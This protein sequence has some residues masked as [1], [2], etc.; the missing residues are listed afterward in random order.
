[1]YKETTEQLIDK[2]IKCFDDLLY[3]YAAIL[4]GFHYLRIKN[5]SIEKYINKI[6]GYN[7]FSEN[8]SKK[9]TKEMFNYHNLLKNYINEKYNIKFI[10]L[11]HRIK[12]KRIFKSY[13]YYLINKIF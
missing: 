12:K 2:N 4:N 5:Y 3:T 7:G 8:Y 1:M 13:L 9:I 6:Y 11:I 10:K